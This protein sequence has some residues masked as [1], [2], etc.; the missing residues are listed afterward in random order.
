MVDSAVTPTSASVGSAGVNST[1]T[2][3]ASDTD[4]ASLDVAQSDSATRASDTA[5]AKL[6][7][8]SAPIPTIH[9]QGRHLSL[10]SASRTDYSFS[11]LLDSVHIILPADVDHN[12]DVK[13]RSNS[14]SGLSRT[15]NTDALR[16]RL[17]NRTT[18][19]D[20]GIAEVVDQ[21]V[22][23]TQHLAPEKT[24]KATV[25]NGSTEVAR[26]DDLV[27]VPENDSVKVSS[28][29]QAFNVR[30]DISLDASEETDLALGD[31]QAASQK[32]LKKS[33]KP[34]LIDIQLT[35][36]P[37]ELFDVVESKHHP[38][39][40]VGVEPS[41]EKT[42]RPARELGIP[43]VVEDLY[44][45]R[46]RHVSTQSESESSTE[47]SKT[48]NTA[49]GVK[50]ES[51][52]NQSAAAAILA[53]GIDVDLS[54]GSDKFTES[55]KTELKNDVAVPA[56]LDGASE[57]SDAGDLSS[58]ADS[59]EFVDNTIDEMELLTAHLAESVDFSTVDV[60][61]HSIF[62]DLFE[63]ADS[64]IPSSSE[65]HL[66]G[67]HALA[68][69]DR[70]RNGLI[71]NK[72]T[73][74]HQSEPESQKEAPFSQ[75]GDMSAMDSA[76]LEAQKLEV[77]RAEAEQFVARQIE[78][79]RVEALKAESARIEAEKGQ[80][81]KIEAEI[82]TAARIEARKAEAAK[83]ETA[84]IEAAKAEVVMIEAAIAVAAKVNPDE[85][86]S[87]RTETD[88][89]PDRQ[90]A[91]AHVNDT[92]IAAYKSSE[93]KAV[94]KEVYDVSSL[95]L[96]ERLSKP[97]TPVAAGD[98]DVSVPES[99]Q[100]L[101]PVQTKKEAA[102]VPGTDLDDELFSGYDSLPP[103]GPTQ[104]RGIIYRAWSRLWN[105]SKQVLSMPRRW[106]QKRKLK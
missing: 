25:D 66:N 73:Q 40:D 39:D 1:D 96:E 2:V 75:V 20:A 95:L 34:P 21:P 28:A 92:A 51:P 30:F 36:E 11:G 18:T 67:T 60:T 53:H 49:K 58:T 13:F 24:D 106:W 26:E 44:R 102:L 3:D 6:L 57:L 72:Q 103:H 16:E 48:H 82:A 9:E 88:P 38:A 97:K 19:E 71:N 100:A 87:A 31:Q 94:D 70:Q 17:K 86:G 105:A 33:A 61:D 85:A 8:T 84:R 45:R 5:A 64:P 32:S 104:P 93:L 65:T 68:R 56:A 83:A 63:T 78:A 101:A 89:I 46:Q 10:D 29:A 98:D 79:E 91:S 90:A 50:R 47:Q 12:D 41:E 81:A 23:E 22:I 14:F 76:R 35:E 74:K 59:T 37:D 80:T 15:L 27:S 69:S 43:E 7:T 77:A 52:P 99:D 42:E 54:A 4:T 62:I 55:E